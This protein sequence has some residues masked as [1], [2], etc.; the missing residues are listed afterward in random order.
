[1]RRMI[2]RVI[3]LFGLL[4]FVFISHASAE[5]ILGC[6]KVAV[7]DLGVYASN[8]DLEGAGKTAGEY[9][10]YY[11]TGDERLTVAER[12]LMQE[13]IKAEGLN[14]EGIIDPEAAQRIAALLGADYLVY[15]N[16]TDVSVSDTGTTVQGVGGVT[17]GTT[18][19][20]IVLR[21]M[22]VT[23]GD[24]VMAAKGEGKSKTSYVAV[25]SKGVG[26]I[27]IGSCTVTYDSVHNAIQKAAA[28]AV[29]V[30]AARLH[31]E[32]VKK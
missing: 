13:K 9:V 22:D 26:F 7:M 1:M 5:G 20:H 24:I 23:T 2:K 31:G 17:I 14:T 3:P 28:D 32:S 29:N 27:A 19:A 21:M 6:P 15:G 12:D 4:L 18:K 25:N 30:L 16:I 10:A 11:L 8:L